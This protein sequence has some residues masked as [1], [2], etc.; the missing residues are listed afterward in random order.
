MNQIQDKPQNNLFQSFN[1]QAYTYVPPPNQLISQQNPNTRTQEY[2]SPKNQ[3]AVLP[4]NRVYSTVQ[5][6]AMNNGQPQQITY[7]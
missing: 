1:S 6:F 4:Q 7:G 2:S 5:S 3:Q